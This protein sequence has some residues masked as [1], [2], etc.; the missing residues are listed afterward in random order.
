MSGKSS[1]KA[2]ILL[3][4]DDD[5]V[6]ETLQTF[7]ELEGYSVDA[8]ATT[9]EALD[10]LAEQDYAAV[11][12]DI[13]L[14]ERSGLD[15]LKHLR[16]RSPDVP[17]ILMTARGSIETVAEATEQGAF[18]YLAKPVDFDRL[19]EVLQRALCLQRAGYD[20]DETEEE[21]P[22]TELVGVS[23][24][25]VEL[26]KLISRTAPTDATVLIEGETG[27]GKEL[28]ARTIH[29]L[30][31][32]RDSPFIAVDCASIPASLMETELFG[33]V[34]GAYTGADR[35]RTGVF[36]AA[37]R[38]TVF[39]DEIGDMDFGLQAKLLRFLQERE[40]RPVGSPKTKK[41][42]VRVIAATNKN[43]QQLVAEGKFR[44]DL[45]YRLSV[46]RIVVPPLRERKGDIPILV[47]FFLK[48]FNERYGR[49][50]KFSEQAIRAL[51]AYTWPGNVRQLQH[52]VERLVILATG[53][54]IDQKDVDEALLSSQPSLG[55][56][57]SLSEVEA[58]QIR[59][60]LAATG[61]NKSRA[62]R[63]LGIERKT[64]YRKLEKLGIE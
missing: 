2:Q 24:P 29:R 6:R 45:W 3:V 43:L 21:L 63:I 58:E 41:V 19:R 9:S 61:G 57:E 49:R 46:V 64:L 18:E 31:P 53:T 7:L 55:A 44:E 35:D 5:A 20:E 25:M 36:E 60:V 59:K 26:Y 56:A 50:V 62:A 17:V 8:V 28:V 14:D 4:E 22:A 10:L 27:T 34:R 39:L 30:S 38:G 13:Y 16:S 40:V 11:V 52:V 42:D 15:L 23:A 33:A 37:N 51:E 48:R 12:S 47:Q 1:R 32:R 54:W